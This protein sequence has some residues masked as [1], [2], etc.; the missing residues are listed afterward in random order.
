[1]DNRLYHCWI[2]NMVSHNCEGPSYIGSSYKLQDQTTSWSKCFIWIEK[3]PVWFGS[4]AYLDVSLA[5]LAWKSTLEVSYDLSINSV[6]DEFREIDVGSRT[7]T[8][9]KWTVDR[10]LQL[11][12]GPFC[13]RQGFLESWSHCSPVDMPIQLSTG[14]LCDRVFDFV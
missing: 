9:L 14:L 4:R 6:H 12:T 10:P 7:A 1:M 11:S 3:N 2:W 13:C 5:A 8:E